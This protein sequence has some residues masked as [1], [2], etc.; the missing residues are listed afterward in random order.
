M[1]GKKTTLIALIALIVGSAPFVYAQDDDME[2]HPV[3]QDTPTLD[4]GISEDRSGF[5]GS[6]DSIDLPEDSPSMDDGEPSEIPDDTEVDL[7]SRIAPVL[8]T[9]P[10]P[11]D[12]PLVE[13]QLPDTMAEAPLSIEL[14][15]TENHA[16]PVEDEQNSDIPAPHEQ[17]E[18]VE[19]KSS[20]EPRITD[21]EVL[22]TEDEQSSELAQSSISIRPGFLNLSDQP[23]P[24]DSE[25]FSI[26]AHLH[27]F[28]NP[29]VGLNLP[30]SF[31]KI[32]KSDS[33][34]SVGAGLIGKY[35]DWKFLRGT[36]DFNTSYVRLLGQ[37]RISVNG[38]FDLGV[39]MRK[40]KWSPFLGPFFRYEN[41][42]LPGKNLAAF[43]FGVGLNLTNWAD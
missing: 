26:G 20:P 30:Y 38:G 35:I 29:W 40:T 3:Y 28:I 12:E 18:Q 2:D 37:N 42:F 36:A 22:I 7:E 9:S 13:T 11:V 33:A 21:P 34:H 43:T 8:P 39:G 1:N 17:V 19:K 32:T 14:Q 15:E 31:W 24:L 25:G 4:E 5:D 10:T 41:I 16:I 23:A 6:E 27:Y